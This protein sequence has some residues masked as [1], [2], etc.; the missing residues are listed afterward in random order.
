MVDVADVQKL[1]DVQKV[2]WGVFPNMLGKAWDLAWTNE[3]LW[4]SKEYQAKKKA[5]KEAKADVA[6]WEKEEQKRLR[7]K[8]R[9]GKRLI[10]VGMKTS[11][12]ALGKRIQ[13]M[14]T[15][16]R[17]GRTRP[18]WRRRRRRTHRLSTNFFRLRIIC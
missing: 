3:F 17:S 2:G 8:T 16:R 9:I 15:G 11:G 18:C 10:A 14:S 13:A 5:D 4:G 6:A 7:K 1:A 12:E